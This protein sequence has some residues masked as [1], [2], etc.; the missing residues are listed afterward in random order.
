MKMIYFAAKKSSFAVVLHETMVVLAVSVIIPFVVHGIPF[1]GNVPIGARFLPLFYAPFVAVVLFR[2]A[3]SI[4]SALAA[5]FLNQ[6]LT[7]SPGFEKGIVL[8]FE[9]V[10]FTLLALILSGEKRTCLGAA[11]LA[12][13]MSKGA[14][15]LLLWKALLMVPGISV[16]A[17][18]LRSMYTAFP[19]IVILFLINMYLNA[20]KDR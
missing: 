16:E 9:L 18:F 11:V 13:I 2:P 5:P 6:L 12:Y 1:P 8:T 15:V 14:S 4:M 10:L 19:G 7:G 20:I 3:V 17:Y